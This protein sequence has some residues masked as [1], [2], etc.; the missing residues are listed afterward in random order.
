MLLCE[1][2][3]EEMHAEIEVETEEEALVQALRGAFRNR[4]DASHLRRLLDTT[5]TTRR[6]RIERVTADERTISSVLNVFERMT[7]ELRDRL[8][9]GMVLD[10]AR[11]QRIAELGHEIVEIATG[12]RKGVG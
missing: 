9:D 7:A 8:N 1:R 10:G 5:W 2:C 3:G 6:Q 12:A 4:G 11:R